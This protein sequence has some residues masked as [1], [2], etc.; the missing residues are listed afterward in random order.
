MTVHDVTMREFLCKFLGANTHIVS[1]E[2]ARST[3]CCINNSVHQCPNQVLFVAQV[4][5]Q[6]VLLDVCADTFNLAPIQTDSHVA[7]V[8][9]RTFAVEKLQKVSVWMLSILTQ[10]AHL[11]CIRQLNYCKT[12]QKWC[13]NLLICTQRCE[14]PLQGRHHLEYR[15][16][17]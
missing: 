17:T 6:Y 7:L 15:T 4:F 11:S 9:R 2:D 13:S 1:A 8:P 10:K 3:L 5:F 12:G 16:A 14:M